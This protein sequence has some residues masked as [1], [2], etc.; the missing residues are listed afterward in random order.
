MPMPRKGATNSE[1]YLKQESGLHSIFL[2][3]SFDT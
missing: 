1:D 2:T 3:N